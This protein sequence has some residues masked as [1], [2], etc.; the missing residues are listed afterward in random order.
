MQFPFF[1]LANLLI[2]VAGI[3]SVLVSLLILKKDSTDWLNRLLFLTFFSWA[4]NIFFYSL[5]FLSILGIELLNLIRDV[6]VCFGILAAFFLAFSGYYLASGKD[7]AFQR[8]NLFIVGISSIL[9]IL[10]AVVN[11]FVIIEN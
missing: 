7:V 2:L 5:V 6:N 11:D 3:F 10:I 1:S 8:K 4:L 9:V